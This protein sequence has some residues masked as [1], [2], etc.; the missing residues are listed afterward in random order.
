VTVPSDDVLSTPEIARRL[1]ELP[2]WAHD[3]AV[4]RRTYR[5]DGWPTTL[6]LVNA[7]GY[8]AEAADH[9]PDL[10]V[11]WGRVTVSLHTHSARGIT[12]Q[13][14]ELARLIEQAALWRPGAESALRGTPRQFVTPADPS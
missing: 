12:A 10:Q 4:I 2:G 13:D 7:I 8:Y 3:G 1:A 6:L 9:H 14:F 5:T 11:S